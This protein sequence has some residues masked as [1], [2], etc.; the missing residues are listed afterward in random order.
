[1]TA[2]LLPLIQV[3]IVVVCVAVTV[4]VA[5]AVHAGQL[6][7]IV[8]ERVGAVSRSL[9]A[10]PEVQE[11]LR[12]DAGVTQAEATARLQPV[13]DLVHAA[14]DVDY[15]VITDVAGIRLTHPTVELR[16]QAVST[17]PG[18]VLA[19]EEFLGTETGTLGESYRAK[20]PIYV[21]G[22]IRG[23]ASV[24]I[25]ESR[26]A[27]D[28]ADARGG[29]LPWALGAG[30]LGTGLSAILGA[31]VNRRLRD[32]DAQTIELEQA[33]IGEA[34]LAAQAHEFRNRLHVIA[35]LVDAGEHADAVGFIQSI[36]PHSPHAP[37]GE[38]GDARVDALL[39]ALAAE[40]DAAGLRLSVSG[41]I[42]PGV[43]ADV[44]TVT[45]LGNLV[46]NAIDA[47]VSAQGS[48]TEAAAPGA[49]DTAGAPG[50][51]RPDISVW[52]RVTTGNTEIRVDD[53]GPGIRDDMI[54]RVCE[55]GFSSRVRRDGGPERGEGLSTV[56]AICA[57][58]AGALLISRSDLGGASV[59]ASW[60]RQPAPVGGGA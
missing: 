51:A 56:Q 47:C 36:V 46:D 57:G 45:V 38:L 27:V 1:M 24:G 39:R 53:S 34:R 7:E 15:V 31:R 3:V 37:T 6:R 42:R 16:G 40:A 23:T 43:V 44:D 25:L 14:A 10:L 19:G 26:I 52:V 5:A 54:D 20:V 50:S 30:V 21:D 33:R 17:D 13:A 2:R 58:G 35:G 32:A 59:T 8:G 41:E 60:A 9:A 55:R 49:G 22:E 4:V 48:G 12:A 11:A 28:A 18:D 29:V